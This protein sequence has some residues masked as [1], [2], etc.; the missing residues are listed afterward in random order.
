MDM[1]DGRMLS[2]AERLVLSFEKMASALEGLNETQRRS[3]A[4]QFPERGEIREAVVSRV[5]TAEDRIRESQGASGTSLDEWLSG[6]EEES[7][8]D[9]GVREREWL[10]GQKR[11]AGAERP[12]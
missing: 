12:S 10:E 2:L 11:V 6:I 1:I 7:E 4:K 8:E 3:F 9:I 5:P